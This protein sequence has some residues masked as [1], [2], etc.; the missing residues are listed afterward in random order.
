MEI[1]RSFY[2]PELYSRRKGKLFFFCLR[3][4]VSLCLSHLVSFFFSILDEREPAVSSTPVTGREFALPDV[5]ME[6]PS[7]IPDDYLH[8]G[9][10]SSAEVNKQITSGRDNNELE[11][12]GYP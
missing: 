6:A 9:A 4:C 8:R 1:F 11:L 12:T 3:N 2:I 10:G 5:A 7:F